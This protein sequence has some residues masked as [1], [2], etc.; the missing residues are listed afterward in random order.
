MRDVARPSSKPEDLD[1]LRYLG[2]PPPDLEA[3]SQMWAP[4][5]EAPLGRHGKPFD[6]HIRTKVKF[7]F[8]PQQ[9]AEAALQDERMR[10]VFKDDPVLQQRFEVFLAAQ[11]GR[12]KDWY[13]VR[14][15]SCGCP[16]SS[17]ADS[18]LFAD[19]LRTHCRVQPSEPPVQRN[20][21]SRCCEVVEKSA[22]FGFS[23]RFACC[24][25]PAS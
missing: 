24:C 10:T 9:D 17:A 4:L 5:D 18:C 15:T 16:R 3:I 22:S 2:L 6:R 21:S 13:L 7:G 23:S 19:L 20:G 12:S 8:V 14:P 25:H 1:A 11:A